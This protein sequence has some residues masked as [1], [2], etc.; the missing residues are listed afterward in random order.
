MILTGAHPE[1]RSCTHGCDG[2]TEQCVEQTHDIVR[3]IPLENDAG[4]L[5]NLPRDLKRA[6]SALLVVRDRGS[7]NISGQCYS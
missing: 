7:E 4:A 1:T 6:D 2:T 3:Y 5:E